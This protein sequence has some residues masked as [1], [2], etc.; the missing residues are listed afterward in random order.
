[1][2]E[3]VNLLFFLSC[4]MLLFFLIEIHW[5]F[6][7]NDF[8]ISFVISCIFKNVLQYITFSVQ[9]ATLFIIL[10][11][12]SCGIVTEHCEP[13]REKTGLRGFRPG[14]TQTDLYKHRKE[15]EA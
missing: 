9:S 6:R 7:Q 5:K 11:D 2:V 4:N 15:L 14:L 13:P 8:C 3:I 10:G 1:M 12:D